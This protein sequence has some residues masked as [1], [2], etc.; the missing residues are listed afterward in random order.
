MSHLIL[1][2]GDLHILVGVSEKNMKMM[3][4]EENGQQQRLPMTEISEDSEVPCH[5]ISFF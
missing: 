3:I 4:L 5:A 2:L 1:T